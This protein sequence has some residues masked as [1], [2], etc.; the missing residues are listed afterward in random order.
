MSRKIQTVLSTFVIIFSWS[1]TFPGMFLVFVKR[2][3]P[4]VSWYQQEQPTLPYWLYFQSSAGHRRPASLST[5]CIPVA[6]LSVTLLRSMSCQRWETG[7]VT[8]LPS[9]S[10]FTADAALLLNSWC[11]LLCLAGVSQ[12]E[13]VG[14][15]ARRRCHAEG[16]GNGALLPGWCPGGGQGHKVGRVSQRHHH[17]CGESYRCL[18][19]SLFKIS[20]LAA[21]SLWG[22]WYHG[23]IRSSK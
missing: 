8:W 3:S 13:P 6:R 18:F 7:W 14:G 5:V 10:D 11:Q 4:E 15:W 19:V 23:K 2:S 20:L 9:L 17:G 21:V 22:H 16:G 12:L 1:W